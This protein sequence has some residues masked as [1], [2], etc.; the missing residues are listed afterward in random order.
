MLKRPALALALTATLLAGL[1]PGTAQAILMGSHQLTLDLL[2]T[3]QYFDF[4]EFKEYQFPVQGLDWGFRLQD[5]Y[6]VDFRD[7]QIP[8]D[9]E[10]QNRNAIR[11]GFVGNLDIGA[12]LRTAIRPSWG[13]E[14]YFKYTPV[15]LVINY[16]GQNLS[17]ATFTRYSGVTNPGDAP[18]LLNWVK[19]DYPTYHVLRFGLNLDYVYFR[20]RNNTINLYGA[21]GGGAV[22]YKMDGK[23]FIPTDYDENEQNE[24]SAP[25][26]ISFYMPNDTFWSVNMGLG[27]I[28]FVHRYFGINVDFRASYSP[29][30]LHRIDADQY[31]DTNK[32]HWIFSSSI[33]YTWRLG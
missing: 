9:S 2:G 7:P 6:D 4:A 29:F 30:Q 26:D 28:F 12:R 3:T 15:D 1:L 19:G 24:P 16:N 17:E 13:L 25:R 18:D 10:L 11:L 8:F 23:L 32:S 31:F 21:A 27:G 5:L 33:G 22:T 20:A 14:G